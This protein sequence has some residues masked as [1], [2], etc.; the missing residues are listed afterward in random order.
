MMPW[1][2]LDLLRSRIHW[3]DFSGMTL[4]CQFVTAGALAIIHVAIIFANLMGRHTLYS[5]RLHDSWPL[6][7]CYLDPVE[8][9]SFLPIPCLEQIWPFAAGCQL[10]WIVVQ[11]PQCAKLMLE[12]SSRPCW[13]PSPTRTWLQDSLCNHESQIGF[14]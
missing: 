4:H 13:L 8:D 14:C 7:L 2:R 10:G 11:G 6:L 5:I 3:D 1:K 9:E 12:R